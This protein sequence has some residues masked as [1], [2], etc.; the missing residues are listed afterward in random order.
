MTMNAYVAIDSNC[1]TFLVKAMYSCERPMDNL[2]D[3]EIAL[4]RTYLYCD[5]ILYISST[6]KSEY[7]K[8][9]DA[10]KERKA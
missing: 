3:Q 1:H 10:F 4:V 6:V 7:E 9:T 8:I 5:K 2:A